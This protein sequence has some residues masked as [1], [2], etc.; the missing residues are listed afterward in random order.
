MQNFA[1]LYCTYTDLYP[2][3]CRIRGDQQHFV[4]RDEL[5]VRFVPPCI[6]V[7]SCWIL[8]QLE[9]FNLSARTLSFLLP[10]NAARFAFSGCLEDLHSFAAWHWRRQAEGP[11]V[12]T[13]QPGTQGSRRI[14]RESWI[15]ADPRLHMGT[16]DPCIEE[17]TNCLYLGRS[18]CPT[19]KLCVYAHFR[20]IACR[21]N[22]VVLDMK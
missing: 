17:N 7:P 14:E 13:W 18:E 5:Q 21:C 12:W 19:I 9:P 8:Y 11:P 20:Y 4:R 10:S 22:N 6:F 1:F 2:C 15:R 3:F 16:A